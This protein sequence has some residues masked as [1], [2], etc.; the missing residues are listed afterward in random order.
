MKEYIHPDYLVVM[1]IAT[2]SDKFYKN[3]K[4]LPGEIPQDVFFHAPME[5]RVFLK[6]I[7]GGGQ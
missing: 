1:H 3:I 5:R 2:W 4:G 6:K 7:G